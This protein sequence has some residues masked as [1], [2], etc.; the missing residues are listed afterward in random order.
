M[1]AA[2]K[3][4]RRVDAFNEEDLQDLVFD[5]DKKVSLNPIDSNINFDGIFTD[6]EAEEE[7]EA[8][9]IMKKS[10]AQPQAFFFST[11]PPA[12]QTSF[13]LDEP[14]IIEQQS[15]PTS[16]KMFKEKSFDGSISNA[17][18]NQMLKKKLFA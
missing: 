5:F 15:K 4:Q 6:D 13:N 2:P 18:R 10:T 9:A 3:K 7:C 16:L 12:D 11:L 1:A 14:A 8:P 17:R